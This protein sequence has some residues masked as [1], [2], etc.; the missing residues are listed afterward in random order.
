MQQS[1]FN[2]LSLPTANLTNQPINQPI[3]PINQPTNQFNQPNY[4]PQQQWLPWEPPFQQLLS[5]P[6][7]TSIFSFS[8]SKISNKFT[9]ILADLFC[10]LKIFNLLYMLTISWHFL[11]STILLILLL[12]IPK[13]RN[14]KIRKELLADY[15]NLA[16]CI[17]FFFTKPALTNK[18]YS[19]ITIYH[20]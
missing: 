16:S 10:H 8:L 3:N 20:N 12:T 5:L 19:N 15:I 17:K 14:N 2:L 6:L 1:F 11:S 9:L 13:D 7:N 4:L 18:K